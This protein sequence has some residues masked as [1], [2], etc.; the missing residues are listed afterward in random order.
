MFTGRSLLNWSCA[1][2]LGLSSVGCF[3][4]KPKDVVDAPPP[5][6]SAYPDTS[7]GIDGSAPASSPSPA[8]IAPATM[9]ATNRT[10][11]APPT[12]VPFELREGETLVNHAIS[13]GET[14]SVIATKYNTTVGRILSANGMTDTRIYAGKSI[15]VPTS[16]AP[17]NLAQNS[18][19]AAAPG[20]YAPAASLAPAAPAATSYD[21]LAGG[22]YPST[23]GAP[24]PPAAV[25][26]STP[27]AVVPPS[28]SGAIAPPPPPPG[29]SLP[30]IPAAP[31]TVETGYPAS[32]SYPRSAPTA[33]S[34]DASRVQFSN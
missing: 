23:T 29:S 16:A 10:A 20:P 25:V 34:F 15:Q 13:P 17:T 14:L 31:A 21:A 11:P 28:A 6:P 33:P 9:A 3:T 5:P 1:T 4:T 2:A 19:P 18:A 30:S 7:G 8:S 12:P 27:A 32:T 22:A 24:A 26:P